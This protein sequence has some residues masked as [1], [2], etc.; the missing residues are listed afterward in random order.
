MH[1]SNLE[2]PA[3]EEQR[4]RFYTAFGAEWAEE[5]IDH[6]KARLY[7]ATYCRVVRQASESRGHCYEVGS[8]TYARLDGQPLEADD[9]AALRRLNLGQSNRVTGGV[10]DLEATHSWECDSGD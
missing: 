5:A 2:L 10:G 7:L 3:A 6:A 9:F 8:T 4:I 1:Y